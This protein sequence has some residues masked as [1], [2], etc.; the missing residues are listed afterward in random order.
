MTNFAT[1]ESSTAASGPCC[2][3]ISRSLDRAEAEA[4]AVR[5][6]AA[7]DPV[8]LQ[9]LSII[10]NSASGEVCACD[11]VAPIGKS[12]PTV[13]HHLKVLA[14]AGLIDGHKRGRWIWYRL[15]NDAV[16][17]LANA[18]NGVVSSSDEPD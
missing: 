1:S 6:S 12:Q 4:L 18:L 10:S 2:D 8:R 13:S 11:F 17:S 5:L 16:G 15:G 14:K 3:Q 9:M 7:A